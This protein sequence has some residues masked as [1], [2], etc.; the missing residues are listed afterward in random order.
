MKIHKNKILYIFHGRFPSEKAASLFAAKS[1]EALANQNKDII[2]LV[3]RRISR[4]KENISEYYKIKENF[5]IVFLPTLDLFFLKIFEKLTFRLS[6]FIFSFSCLFYLFLKGEKEDIVYSNETLPLL[7]ASYFFKNTLY[8]VHDFPEKNFSFYKKLFKNLR[9]ILVTNNW[10]IEKLKKVFGIESKKFIYEPNA[11]EIKFFD[12]NTT[13]ENARHILELPKDKKIIVYTGHLYS[14]KGVDTLIDASKFLSDDFVVYL[15]GGTDKDL[16]EYKEK[17]RGNKKVIL[18]GHKRHKE[19]PL[20]QKSA[21]VLVLPN[22]AKE[23]ISKYYTSPMKLFE[24]MASKRVIVASNI[25]SIS[26]IL[27][28]KNAL[29]FKPDNAKDLSEKI[30]WTFINHGKVEQLIKQ[31]FE[32]VQKYTWYERAKRIISNF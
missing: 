1:C 29:M 30:K 6:L 10:K 14:W 12:I 7:L 32:D 28:S 18:A 17:L 11:V 5:K 16:E 20:W 15:V 23:D 22:T 2:L 24:Y 27:N 9:W 3:P 26:E 19:I 13:K 21:D 25:P 4:S 31:S 8:E